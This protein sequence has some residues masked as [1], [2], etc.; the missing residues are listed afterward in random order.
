MARAMTFHRTAENSVSITANFST[1]PK[2]ERKKEKRRPQMMIAA[3]Q[4]GGRTSSV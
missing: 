1:V 2:K 4:S 3:T